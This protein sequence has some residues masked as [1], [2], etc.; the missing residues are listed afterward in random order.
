MAGFDH[1][2]QAACIRAYAVVAAALTALFT[3]FEFVE[4][5]ASVGQGHYR[6]FDALVYV[7]LTVP[8][9]LVQVTPVSILLG[10]L[11]A[12][13]NLGRHSELTAFRSLGISERR[14]IG[15]VACVT[16]PIVLVLFLL[17]EFVIPPGQRLAQDRRLSALPPDQA[18]EGFWAQDAD[19]YLNIRQ[20]AGGHAPKDLDIY[21]FDGGGVL[22]SFI[23]AD[24]AAFGSDGN[25]LLTGVTRKTTASFQ[26]RTEH[27]DRLRWQSF[28]SPGQLQ[29]LALPL[30]SMP[31]IELYRYVRGLERRH[32]QA[33]RYERELWTELDLPL[34]LVAMTVTAAPFVFGP[35][36]AQGARHQL[37]IGA[38]VGVAFT[39]GQQIARQV[40]VSLNVNPAASALAP[41]LM[42]L[43]AAI[44]LVRRAPR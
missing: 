9:R 7:L 31:P 36:R 18:G 25:W 29:L 43:A 4:Q 10:S 22:Q 14:I 33:R 37:A 13:N 32:Q 21:E 5:L 27:L 28:I 41:S 15:S 11:L 16:I 1:Y 12:L 26:F 35:S 40:G 19:Q 44:C 34:S 38:A 30:E 2:I 42:V 8:Y 39:V 6:A 17:A 23:H 3:L 20:F 24:G